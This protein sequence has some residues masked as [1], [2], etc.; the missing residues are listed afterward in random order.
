MAI[1]LTTLSKILTSHDPNELKKLDLK[2]STNAKIS[3]YF[4]AQRAIKK[5][6]DAADTLAEMRLMTQIMTVK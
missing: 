4:S 1:D 2:D 5:T 6:P 3:D